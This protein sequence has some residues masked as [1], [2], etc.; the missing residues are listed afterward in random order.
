VGDFF[1]LMAPFQPS[2][3]AGAADPFDWGDEQHVAGLLTPDFELEFDELDAPYTADSGEA[4]WAELSSFYGPTKTLADSLGHERRL[5]LQRAVVEFYEAHR[6]G[7]RV[8][9]QRRYLL[10]LGNRR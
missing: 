8:H 2:S 7:G 6:S 4:A 10:V 5:E 3:L 1:R 9:H